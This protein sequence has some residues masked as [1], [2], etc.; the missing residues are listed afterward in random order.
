LKDVESALVEIREEEARKAALNSKP[1][2]H[3]EKDHHKEKDYH[4]NGKEHGKEKD[5]FFGIFHRKSMSQA[6][7]ELTGYSTT[8]CIV[9]NPSITSSVSPVTSP[10]IAHLDYKD[11]HSPAISPTN[12]PISTPQAI[13]SAQESILDRLYSYLT[14]LQTQHSA[15]M[16]LFESTTASAQRTASPSPLPPMPEE[17]TPTDPISRGIDAI[18]IASRMAS[19]DMRRQSVATLASGAE[20]SNVWF[21][22]VDGG[23]EE[24]VLD[25]APESLEALQDEEAEVEDQLSDGD[26]QT[27]SIAADTASIAPTV[28]ESHFTSKQNS[29]MLPPPPPIV[30]RAKLPA[31]TSG[32]EISLFSVLKKN[33]GKVRAFRIFTVVCVDFLNASQDLSTVALPVSFNEP[34]SLLQRY[35][36][37]KFP[38]F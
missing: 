28:T 23:A 21:D 15:L 17:L 36:T 5:G 33:V 7:L 16:A 14:A 6:F 19:P 2:K 8:I 20:S 35:S 29:V 31:P 3:K 4:L 11:P 25:A 34:I 30:R 26:H 24:F 10:D 18:M 32:D 27:G 22:A 13:P 12:S 37:R 1:K 9:S 38:S